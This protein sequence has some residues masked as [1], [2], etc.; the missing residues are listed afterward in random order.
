MSRYHCVPAVV[1]MGGLLIALPAAG[2]GPVAPAPREA[3]EADP[4]YVDDAEFFE[5]VNEKLQ[6]LA[7]KRRGWTRTSWPPSSSRGGRPSP[8]PSP[9][10]SR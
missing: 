3:V 1:L 7:E 4:W 2:D 8:W 9:A 10:S 5:G 6:H